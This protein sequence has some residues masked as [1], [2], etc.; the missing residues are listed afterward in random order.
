[1]TSFIENLDTLFTW[2]YDYNWTIK[3]YSL[4]LLSLSTERNLRIWS[5]KEFECSTLQQFPLNTMSLDQPHNSSPWQNARLRWKVCCV[6]SYHLCSDTLITS[7]SL[8]QPSY[9][10]VHLSKYLFVHLY[11][12]FEHSIMLL[13]SDALS[14]L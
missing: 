1:M 11:V 3:I 8:F 9:L 2:Q 12:T 10:S 7:N 13:A 5:L 4:G 6:L 14:V